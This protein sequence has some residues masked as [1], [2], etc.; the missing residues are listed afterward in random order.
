MKSPQVNTVW[1]AAGHYAVA[2]CDPGVAVEHFRA[3]AQSSPSTGQAQLA[4]VDAALA[5]LATE[6]HDN[7]TKAT[8]L[9]QGRGIFSNMD[10]ALPCAERCSTVLSSRIFRNPGAL[11]GFN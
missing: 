11:L 10:P 4:V 6:Q 7:L 5:L 9:M 2:M 1:M 3:V 8:Q